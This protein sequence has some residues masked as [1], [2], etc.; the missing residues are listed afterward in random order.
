M[1][2]RQVDDETLGEKAG[3]RAAEFEVTRSE[4]IRSDQGLNRVSES[5]RLSGSLKVL[6]CLGSLRVS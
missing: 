5:L 4:A 6:W 2:A 3:N 1:V